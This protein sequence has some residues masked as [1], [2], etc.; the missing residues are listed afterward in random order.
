MGR[1]LCGF[2]GTRRGFRGMLSAVF[3][4][5]PLG[6]F[7]DTRPALGTQPVAGRPGQQFLQRA[8]RLIQPRLLAPQFIQ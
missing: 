3:F 1:G 6:R 2:G 7:G 4:P 8:N 5:T